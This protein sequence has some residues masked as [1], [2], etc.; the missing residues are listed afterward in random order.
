MHIAHLH[1]GDDHKFLW[2][3]HVFVASRA[4]GGKKVTF[5]RTL[6]IIRIILELRSQ[7]PSLV[8]MQLLCG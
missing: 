1:Y 8:P 6:E 2:Q 3:I 5:D 4:C 7:I